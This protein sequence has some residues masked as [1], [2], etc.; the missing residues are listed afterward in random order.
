M[1][2]AGTKETYR[3][4]QCLY[5][6]HQYE[7]TAAYLS[8]LSGLSTSAI[9]LLIEKYNK[10]GPPSVGYKPK[11]GRHHAY[12]SVD[13]EAALLKG[14]SEKAAR[15]AILTVGD[16]REDVERELRFSV[17][18]DYL[19]GL[20]KRHHWKKKAPRPQHIKKDSKAQARFKKKLKAP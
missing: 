20:L 15:G 4:W 8:D 1:Q 18:D 9:Y 6:A 5:L 16:I 11:G 2:Q 3:R 7:L 12:L 17:S 10:E 13:Q 19:W 14:L